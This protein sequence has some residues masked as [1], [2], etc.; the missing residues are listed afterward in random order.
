MDKAQRAEIIAKFGRKEGDTGSP[1]VQIAL[2]SAR[3]NE[4]TEHLKVNFKDNST[5]R[6]LLAM[7]SLRK[8]LL[9]YLLRENRAKY[10][11]ITDALGIRR[12]K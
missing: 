7:V 10:I 11:E 6:G 9:S 5:R 2:L 4:L 12:T 3:I 8:K 1:E